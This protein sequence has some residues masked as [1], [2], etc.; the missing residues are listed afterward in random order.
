MG[1]TDPVVVCTY[2][3]SGLGKST[4]C[5]YSFPTALFVAA[6]GALGSIESTCGY[7]PKRTQV[8][9]IPEATK[10]IEQVAG[11]FE[12][13]VIDDFSFLAEQTFSQFE[14]KYNGFKLWGELRDAALEFRDKARFAKMNVV[15]NCFARN[16]PFVTNEGTKS[17]TDYSDGD[18]IQVLTHTGQ[19]KDAVVRSYGVRPMNRVTIT[20]GKA[21][22]VVEC[23]PDH[24]WLL[25]NGDETTCLT[26]GDSLLP[27]PKIF[28]EFD[29]FGSTEEEQDAWIQG[30]L[31]GDGSTQRRQSGRFYS[32]IRLCGEKA[33]HL[34]KFTLRGYTHTYPPSC[35][36]DP[37]VY[38][39]NKSEKKLIDS[40]EPRLIRAFIA[41]YLAADGHHNKNKA[42]RHFN[43]FT[44]IITY[45]EDNAAFLRQY[46][47]VAGCYLVSETIAPVGSY[48]R[49]GSDLRAWFVITQGQSPTPGYGR[50]FVVSSIEPVANAEAWCLEVEDDHSFVLPWGVATGNCWEQPPKTKP[51]GTKLRGGPQLPGKLPESI[52]ALCD[53]VL[54]VQQ[55]PKRKPWPVVYR[56]HPDPSFV[57]KD[58]TNTA[59]SCD[60][61]PMNLAEI[62]RA[63]GIAISRHPEY[64]EQEDHVE[65]IAQ[66]LTG[67][68]I[69][70]GPLLNN[71]YAGLLKKG[72]AAHFAKWTLRDAVDRFVI[73]RAKEQAANQFVTVSNTL[74]A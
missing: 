28:Q 17:F 39:G 36:G 18:K 68:V 10:L 7:S 9:T 31:V 55:E 34:A 21:K 71:I 44:G 51:D 11:K 2:G 72:L 58:R 23:T 12:T 61:A 25:R 47:P 24:R 27:A 54:R 73:R 20:R 37:L 15:V 66:S 65:A 13:V 32:S 16:T 29:F 60:P 52:P 56:C 63:S 62:L 45:N 3:A 26:V 40:S 67:E 42:S 14:K 43:P 5:G 19:W 6:P 22:Y 30:M 46:L 74:G 59:T 38:L 50:S 1:T 48:S 8:N 64:K 35:H 57:M 4:D 69:S 49:A 70:D 33:N 41:G 53:I